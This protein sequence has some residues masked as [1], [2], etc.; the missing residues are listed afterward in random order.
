MICPSCSAENPQGQRYCGS[1]G[2][3]LA[4]ASD[5]SAEE[6]KVVTVLFCDLAGFTAA[7]ESA[8]PE[9]VRAHLVPY[10]R[11]LREEIERFGG[12]VDKFSGDGVMAVF[13]APTAHEDDA[14]RAVRSALRI[15]ERIDELNDRDRTF[16]L[17]ARIGINTGEAIVALGVSPEAGEDWVA[18]DVV[19]T[20]SRLQ[21]VATPGS[22][23][24]G[25]RTY[26]LTSA[27][28]EYEPLTPVEVKGKADPVPIW[29]VVSARS[30]TGAERSA[31]SASYVGRERERGLM[32]SVFD[33]AV[34][35][36]SVQLVTIVGEPGV[37]KS[38]LVAE[39]FG[40]AQDRTDLIRWHQG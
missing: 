22:I 35:D 4:A 27:E 15:L 40:H 37:G 5:R 25:E 23:V 26:R 10:Q 38:R 3:A 29:R 14:E 12:T 2:S 21:G 16:G 32:M 7:S 34:A 18:G 20:A 39:L 1:C 30:R 11:S 33:R 8:D 9:D 36:P 31:S 6:R 13:G 28:I 24:V 17:P 19:N